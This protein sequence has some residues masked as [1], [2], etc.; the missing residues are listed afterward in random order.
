MALYWDW[1][2]KCG[3]ATIVQE[4]DGERH[5]YTLSL[6]TGN[7]FLIMLNEYEEDGKQMYGMASFWVDE[8]HMKRCLG[9]DKKGGHTTN[10][11]RDMTKIRLHKTKC[12][13]LKK[14]V[15]AL[16]QA[17]DNLTIEIYID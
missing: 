5:E 16:V 10:I 3:E 1:K 2:E 9:L 13:N 15:P 17:F 11:H 4:Y 12:R 8:G 14:I 7:A 6:Y